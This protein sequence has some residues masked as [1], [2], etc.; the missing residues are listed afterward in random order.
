MHVGIMPSKIMSWSWLLHIQLLWLFGHYQFSCFFFLFGTTSE[1]GFCLCL[2][3]KPSWDQSI[4]FISP[5]KNFVF[6]YRRHK[7]LDP[8]F[9]SA[10]LSSEVSQSFN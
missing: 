1:A 3:V 10:E 2:Q 6:V 5:D 9:K 7:L 4:L 8:R